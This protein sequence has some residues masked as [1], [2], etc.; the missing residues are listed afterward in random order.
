MIDADQIMERA[1]EAWRPRERLLI[2]EWAD[3]NRRL[4]Q[5]GPEGGRWRTARA[6]YQRGMMD[7]VLEPGVEEVWHMCSS[8]VGK[9]E[10]ILNTAGFFMDHDPASI[11]MV[12]PNQKPMGESF[13]KDRIAPMIRET[14]A[15]QKLVKDPRSRDS[16]NTLLHKEFP[17]GHLTIAGAN[18]PAG[19]ASRPVRVVLLD[20]VDRFPDSAGSEGDPVRLAQ[21]RQANYWN[22]VF[23]A[24]ST[25]TIKG[26][27]RMEKGYLAG[28]KRQF[29][30]PCPHCGE[31]T[32]LAWKNFDFENEGTVEAPLHHCTECERPMYQ[33]DRDVLLPQGQWVAQ[34]EFYGIISTHIWAAY[35][36]WVEWSTLAKKYLSA[37]EGG[38]ELLKTFYNTLLGES[39]E[40][41][42]GQVNPYDLESRAR[43]ATLIRSEEGEKYV[44]PD[45]ALVLTAGVDVQDDRLECEVVGWGDHEESW[46]IRYEIIN[47]S[48]AQAH[49]W[50]AL[51]DILGQGYVNEDGKGISLPCAGVDTGDGDWAQEVYAYCVARMAFRRGVLPFKGARRFDAP[52]WK[53]PR[54]PSKGERDKTHP[55]MIGV[56]QIK[57]RIRNYMTVMTGSGCMHFPDHYTDKYFKGLTAEKLETINTGNAIPARKWVKIR[58]RNEPLDCRVYAYAAMKILNPDWAALK[59]QL[60]RQEDGKSPENVPK[61]AK[62][63]IKRPKRRANWVNKW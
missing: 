61:P 3:K 32:P 60:T 34:R 13:S 54:K 38:V 27:S 37:K 40:E 23:V 16:N 8:Q 20:E 35:S 52:I 14:P 19:L 63:A 4:P 10:I 24:T 51:D 36:P 39:F 31:W 59:R 47:G 50:Q 7:A 46:S 45:G 18:S 43:T 28:D 42:G 26:F 44:V 12:Q 58:D 6:E 1:M 21:Q 56:S 5:S 15:L 41:E 62:K 53:P 29:L 17:G 9:S 22:R 55:Y 2:S 33:R 48:P 11:L 25:P 57:L 49:T 30:L